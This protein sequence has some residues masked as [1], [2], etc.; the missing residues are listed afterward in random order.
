MSVYSAAGSQVTVTRA[1]TTLSHGLLVT[2]PRSGTPDRV[3]NRRSR[4]EPHYAELSSE[5]DRVLNALAALT[6]PGRVA[7]ALVSPEE[8]VVTLHGCLLSGKAAVPV[9]LRLSEEE[10][11][12]RPGRRG[13]A[14]N[15]AAAGLE[16]VGCR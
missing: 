9:D 3:A 5:A 4:A 12:R 2:P 1:E 14:R 8:F 13:C 15:R 10:R 11:D 6:D 7:L 16:R